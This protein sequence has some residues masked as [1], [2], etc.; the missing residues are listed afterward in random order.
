ASAPAF[1]PLQRGRL[2]VRRAQLSHRLNDLELAA[3]QYEAL[4][5]FG[6][7]TELVEIRARST[8]GKTLLAQLRGN[9]PEMLRLARSAY[10]FARSSGL[11]SLVSRSALARM[12]ASSQLGRSSEALV[13]AWEMYEAAIGDPAEEASSLVAIGQLLL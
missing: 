12:I 9:Y 6:R 3:A 13:S 10:R 7:A 5:R 8:L 11:P 2:G 1:T 4:D